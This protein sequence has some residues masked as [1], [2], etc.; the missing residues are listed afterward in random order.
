[1]RYAVGKEPAIADV[2]DPET[3]Y[4]GTVS[5]G[6]ARPVAFLSRTLLVSLETDDDEVPVVRVYRVRDR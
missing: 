3:G 2:F 6:A 4:T 1:M 5:L